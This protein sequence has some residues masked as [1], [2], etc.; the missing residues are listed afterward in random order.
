MYYP[1]EYSRI[2][3]ININEINFGHVNLYDIIN[4]KV[5]TSQCD[6]FAWVD[7]RNK[8]SEVKL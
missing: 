7:F 1:V 2:K 8:D 4:I 3:I 5:I 6:R